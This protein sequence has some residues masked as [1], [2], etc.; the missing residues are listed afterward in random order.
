MA[1]QTEKLVNEIIAWAEEANSIEVPE[2][3]VSGEPTIAELTVVVNR[4]VVRQRELVELEPPEPS[5]GEI[6]TGEIPAHGLTNL[7]IPVDS[8]L[9][10]PILL[11]LEGIL[12]GIPEEVYTTGAT[13]SLT[14]VDAAGTATGENAVEVKAGWTLPDNTNIPITAVIPYQQADDGTFE[15]LGEPREVITNIRYDTS[16]QKL[17]K[18]VRYDWGMFTTTESSSWVE[19]AIATAVDCTAV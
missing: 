13:I 14:P 17:Q 9:D 7:P 1:K 2:A 12:L 8:G 3:L 5:P 16:S 6:E 19:P 15:V 11:P 18:K 10:E 4:L